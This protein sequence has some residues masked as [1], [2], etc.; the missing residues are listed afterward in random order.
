MRIFWITAAR[1]IALFALSYFAPHDEL[2]DHRE[3]HAMY[4]EPS[5]FY[6][7]G[8]TGATGSNGATG[9]INYM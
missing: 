5:A 8:I 2:H 7:S 4:H 9:G 6:S 3:T 1:Y